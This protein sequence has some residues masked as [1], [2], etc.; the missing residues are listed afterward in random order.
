ML[1]RARDGPVR[2][3]EGVESVGVFGQDCNTSLYP[4]GGES[5]EPNKLFARLSSATSEAAEPF[6]L[7]VD[8]CSVAFDERK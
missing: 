3:A 4:I 5:G 2:N 6:P 7:F 1:Q 8:P